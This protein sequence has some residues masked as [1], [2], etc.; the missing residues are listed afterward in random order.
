MAEKHVEEAGCGRKGHGGSRLRK[1]GWLKG[2]WRKPVEEERVVEG[3]MG[4]VG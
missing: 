2:S 1:K 3:D 4:E